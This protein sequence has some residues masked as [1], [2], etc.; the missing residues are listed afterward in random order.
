VRVYTVDVKGRI[1]LAAVSKI[2]ALLVSTDVK[3]LHSHDYKSDFYAWFA[4]RRLKIGLVSTAHGS[5][6]DSLKKRLYLFFNEKLVWHRFD[7]II[8]VSSEIEKT[9]LSSGYTADRVRLV[10]NGLDLDTLVTVQDEDDAPLPINLQKQTVFAVIGRLFPDKGHLVFLEA[11][12]HVRRANEQVCALIIGDGPFRHDID[13][14]IDRLE[15][16]DAVAML[17]NRSSMRRLYEK[18]D[19]LVIASLREG[20]PYVLLEAMAM[21][22]N[23]IATRVGE[24]PNIIE[25]RRTGLLV[26]PGDSRQLTEVMLS[27]LETSEADRAQW[28]KKAHQIVHNSYTVDTM[29]RAIE[30]IYTEAI[31]SNWGL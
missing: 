3:L 4:S 5:T 17:G 28:R 12:A 19:C 26:E 1:D 9:L 25:N 30:K 31:S 22:V 29:T 27:Y 11:F 18:I 20:L 7:R 10:R 23:V 14:Y 2:R 21:G 13:E 16:G 24:I 8:A 15:L 6:R